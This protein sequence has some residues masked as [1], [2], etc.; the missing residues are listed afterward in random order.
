MSFRSI[1][2][3]LRYMERT[4]PSRPGAT[5][6]ETSLSQSD[7]KILVLVVLANIFISPNEAGNRL[8]KKIQKSKSE[9]RFPQQDIPSQAT[10]LKDE[11]QKE[12]P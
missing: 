4:S 3:K 9:H 7:R 8:Q 2:T 6:T 5:Q 10:N 1:K 12:F 11:R